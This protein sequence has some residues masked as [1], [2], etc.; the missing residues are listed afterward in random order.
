VSTKRRGRTQASRPTASACAFD[1]LDDLARDPVS[2]TDIDIDNLRDD[3]FRANRHR[4][5][6]DVQIE[7]LKAWAETRFFARLLRH[8]T[9]AR[10]TL[11]EQLRDSEARRLKTPEA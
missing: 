6:E 5:D 8:E 9:S 11:E 7:L 4:I 2:T 1:A 10:R 3:W